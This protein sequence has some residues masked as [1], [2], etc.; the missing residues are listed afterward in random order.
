[1]ENNLTNWENAENW[2]E[3]EFGFD[4]QEYNEF[5]DTTLEVSDEAGIEYA[6][7]KGFEL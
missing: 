5:M 6:K 7:T 2:V 3:G 1:M 4:S